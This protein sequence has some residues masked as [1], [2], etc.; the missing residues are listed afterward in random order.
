MLCALILSTLTLMI[1]G[2]PAALYGR[3]TGNPQAPGVGVVWIACAVLVS[4][5]AIPNVLAALGLGG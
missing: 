4:L 5:P 2:L 3:L 1:S